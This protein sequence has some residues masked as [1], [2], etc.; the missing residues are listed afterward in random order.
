M[1]ELGELIR[2]STDIIPAVDDTLFYLWITEVE[3]LIYKNFISDTKLITEPLDYEIISQTEC[4]HI[5][6]IQRLNIN[7][8]E[9][10]HGSAESIVKD[11]IYYAIVK[12]DECIIKISPVPNYIATYELYVRW[13]PPAKASLN[14][15]IYLPDE[16]LKILI[17]YCKAMIYKEA[18]EVI[19]YNNHME[20][21]NAYLADFVQYLQNQHKEIY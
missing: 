20:D 2:A 10:S 19:L 17:S 14:D 4:H 7:G 11:H 9:Y 8:V 15:V 1:G 12:N 3:Q 21:Y 5:D 13:V 16:W 6:D 18:S